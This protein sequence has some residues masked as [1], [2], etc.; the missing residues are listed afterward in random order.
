[1]ATSSRTKVSSK[2]KV[3]K[4]R[5]RLKIGAVLIFLTL[6]ILFSSI[7]FGIVSKPITNIYIS[8][9]SYL[10]DQEII[11]MAKL[12]SYPSTITNL[13]VLIKKRLGNNVLIKNATVKKKKFT[14]VYINIEE[15]R[16]IFF[17]NN[18]HETVLLD[19]SL[20]KEQMMSPILVNYVPDTI[21]SSFV[22]AMKKVDGNVLN[23][24]SEIIYKPNN[25]DT[26]RFLFIMDDDN[27]VYLTLRKFSNINN[28]VNIVKK[29]GNKKGVLYLDS[30]EYFEVLDN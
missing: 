8:G 18:T 20:L 12:E 1:M 27:Y 4:K 16:P 15:N 14:K 2:K 30:G 22:E 5:R 26:E 24:T 13:S 10:T 7:V 6:L 25:I 28:Y 21:Y 11:E 9:N 3:I 17:N 19:G 29:F 23:R